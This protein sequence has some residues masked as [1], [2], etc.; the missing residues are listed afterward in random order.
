MNVAKLISV[1]FNLRKP[2]SKKATPLYMIMYYWNDKGMKIQAKIPTGYKVLP[3]LWDSKHQIPIMNSKDIV[4]SIKQLEELSEITSYIT[5]LRILAYQNNFCKFDILKENVNKQSNN[6]NMS[7]VTPQFINAKRTPKATKMLKEYLMKYAED[8]KV[9]K[10][11][12]VEYQNN[13]KIFCEW[14]LSTNQTDSAK[15]FSQSSFVDFISWLRNQGSS[16]KKINKMARVIGRI[17]KYIAS[18]PQGAKCG[19]V[20][21]TFT[22]LKEEDKKQKCEILPEEIDAFKNVEVKNDKERYY[23]DLFLLQLSTGQRISDT[24]KLIKGDYEVSGNTIILT[25]IKRGTKAYISETKEVTELLEKIKTNP[26]NKVKSKKDKGLG[27]FIKVLSARAGLT[28]ITPNGMTLC[29]EISSHY[30]RHTFVTQRLREGYTFEQV[31]KM[32]GDT[33]LMIERIYGHPTDTD[34]IASL[35]L[36]PA[37]ANTPTPQVQASLQPVVTKE[38]KKPLSKIII[39]K[40]LLHLKEIFEKRKND[41]SLFE[42]DFFG[43]FLKNEYINVYHILLRNVFIKLNKDNNDI[44]YM[45]DKELINMLRFFDN[46]LKLTKEEKTILYQNTNDTEEIIAKCKILFEIWL[47]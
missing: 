32:I 43:S 39:N 14:I 20:P 36:Q 47:K 27:N 33:P 44:M 17:I 8:R 35:Q 22:P 23:K 24:L 5:Q 6:S 41:F 37:A 9:K 15:C 1:N 4:L 28:R 16:A 38:D 11:S 42:L 18:T 45:S 46:D 12:L 7:P 34:I 25:T 29:E 2:L 40:K 30:A 3:S 19:V 13:I 31:G 10:T 26:E 21:V